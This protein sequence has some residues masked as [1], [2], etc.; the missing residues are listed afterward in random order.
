VAIK[1]KTENIVFVMTDGLRWQELFRG[2]DPALMNKESGV[3]DLDALKKQFWRDS[4]EER[5]K[6]LMPFLW[7]E[8]AGK[9]QIFGNRDKGSNMSVTNG[10]NFSYPGYNE[11]LTGFAD[12]RIDSN[13]KVPNPNVTVL[14]W[15]NKNPKYKGKVAAFGAWDVISAAV[16][17]ERGGFVANAGYDPLLAAPVTD[18]IATI[19][20]LKAETVVW[21]DEPFDSFAFQTAMEYVKLHKPR[22][23]YISLGETDD[24]AHDGKYELYLKSANRV[25]QYLKQVWDTLQ[26]MPQY[27]GKTTMIFSPDHGRGEAPTEWKGHG[28][29]IPDSKYI[30]AAFMGP[31]TPV[32]GERSNIPEL[33]QSQ[34]AATLA[35]LLGEDYASA[36]KR[37]GRPI[38]DVLPH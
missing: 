10:F 26:A 21:G 25:D 14:E 18:K 6:A 33:T 31:D 1:P 4:I 22:V 3:G 28:Q 19:N 12:P 29:R 11:T 23:L 13:K 30:W 38:Q 27:K 34:L 35:A 36:E 32:M 20:K 16:N 24:W 9:G 15:L 7:T 8:I 37:A 5:R 2:A 17:G